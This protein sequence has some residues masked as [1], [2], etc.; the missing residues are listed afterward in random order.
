MG[1]TGEKDQTRKT[2]QRDERLIEIRGT[3]DFST[4]ALGTTRRH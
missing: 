4:F 2:D 1:V 3:R